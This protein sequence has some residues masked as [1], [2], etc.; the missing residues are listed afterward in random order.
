MTQ[1]VRELWI[2]G[3]HRVVLTT[4]ERCVPDQD[5]MNWILVLNGQIAFYSYV[6]NRINA[7]GSHVLETAAAETTI[8][9]IGQ[10]PRTP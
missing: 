5:V 4:E 2:C 9:P 10:D 1:Q 6:R 3:G 8:R 7:H